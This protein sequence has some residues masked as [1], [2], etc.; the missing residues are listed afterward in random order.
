M[1]DSCIGSNAG[2]G[3][4]CGTT[5]SLAR[6]FGSVWK[7]GSY[8]C[9]PSSGSCSLKRRIGN[10]VFDKPLIIKTLLRNFGEHA[11][12]LCHI[13]Y[14]TSESISPTDIGGNRSVLIA[15]DDDSG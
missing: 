6:A 12:M 11:K 14:L 4:G 2:K 15:T 5:R 8:R 9:Y 3:S 10:S 7:S 13:L 1:L